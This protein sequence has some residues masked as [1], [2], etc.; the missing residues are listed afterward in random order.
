MSYTH[1]TYKEQS[2]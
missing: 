2:N 1:R